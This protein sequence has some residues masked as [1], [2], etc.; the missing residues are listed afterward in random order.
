MLKQVSQSSCR[1]ISL[2]LFPGML[3]HVSQSVFAVDPITCFSLLVFI[4]RCRGHLEQVDLLGMGS[5]FFTEV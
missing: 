5:E 4:V 3:K 1:E 2:T